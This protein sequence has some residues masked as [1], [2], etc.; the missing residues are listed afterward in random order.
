MGEHRTL[1]ERTS[2]RVAARMDGLH[3]KD[4]ADGGEVYTGPLA[5]AAL[6]AVGARAMTVDNTIF[7]DESF[8]TSTAEDRALY[9]H[10]RVHQMNSGGTDQ[11]GAHDAEEMAAR[12]IERMV[13]HRSSRGEDTETVMRDAATAAQSASDPDSATGASAPGEGAGETAK[14][15][16][17]DEA[18][19][20]YVALLA[21]G[22]NHTMIV[23]E[24]SQYVVD[25]IAQIRSMSRTRLSPTSTI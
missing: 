19:A 7:V 1:G 23:R 9:A 10:E 15:N 11:H 8:D 17:M 13:L 5:R 16:P 25:Q 20:A 18:R 24:L 6:R 4:M 12:A 22:K 21:Q 14:K 3:R 2:L